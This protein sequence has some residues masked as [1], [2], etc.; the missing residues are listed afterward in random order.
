MEGGPPYACANRQTAPANAQTAR[1]RP[2]SQTAEQPT[3]E[4]PTAEQRLLGDR[5]LWDRFVRVAQIPPRPPQVGS[6]DRGRLLGVKGGEDPVQRRLEERTRLGRRPR[7]PQALGRRRVECVD[8]EP[9]LQQQPDA[10]WLGFA[11]PEEDRREASRSL[12]LVHVRRE[13]RDHLGWDGKRKVT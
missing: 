11:P 12:P 10:L 2:N 1:S 9:V 8:V 3:A 5:R 13:R 7:D 6:K 4:Q